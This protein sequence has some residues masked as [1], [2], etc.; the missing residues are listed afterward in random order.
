MSRYQTVSGTT[1][2]YTNDNDDRVTAVGTD[3]YSYNDNGD[4]TSKT[5][6]GTTYNFSY[7]YEGMIDYYNVGGS[8]QV[9]FGYDAL[10]RR[11]FRST[12]GT[13]TR[14]Y[15]DGNKILQESQGGTITAT[16]AYGNSLLR[17]DGEFPLFDGAGHERTVTNSSQTVTGTINYDSFGNTVGFTGSS[18]SPYMYGANSGNHNVGTRS[19]KKDF[20]LFFPRPFHI[21]PAVTR[22][23][24]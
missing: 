3:S 15:F 8:N 22:W 12:G 7:T 11:L 23:R 16:Y 24:I 4:T 14:Y 2:S 10:G 6:G 17:K 18:A 13:T 20:Q 5:V 1:T 21:P 19:S 9:D